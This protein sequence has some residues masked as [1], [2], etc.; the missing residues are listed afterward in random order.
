MTNSNKPTPKDP[1][2]LQD[3][4]GKVE[5]IKDNSEYLRG[6][7][8]KGLQN[9][10][11][12]AMFDDDTMLIKFHGIY[13]QDDRDIRNER[14]DRKL[15]PAYSFMIRL[16]LPGGHLTA[17][18]WIVA[19]DIASDQTIQ[20]I[21]L[22]TR[23]AIQFHGILK[24]DLAPT[25][26]RYH[27]KLL[28]SIAGCGD[29][30]RNVMCSPNPHLSEHH[31]E[32]YD[33]S[34]KISEHLMPTS[35][36]YHEIFVDGKL[37]A[38]GEETVEPLY[39]KH[40]LPRKFKIAIAIPPYNDVDIHAND[41][42]FIAIVE[43]DKLIG[44]NV[45]VGGG[46]GMSHGDDT[47]YPRLASVIGFVKVDDVLDIAY[48]TVQ[49]QRDFGNRIDRKLA[50]FKYTID[51]HSLE[52]FKQELAERSGVNIADEVP[53]I[54]TTNNDRYGWD[55]DHKGRSHLTLFIEGGRVKDTEEYQLKTALRK[56]AE[57]NL[58]DFRLTGNQNIILGNVA[59][60]YKSKI[61]DILNK[62]T[63]LEKT[64]GASGIRKSAIACVA[65][66]TCPLAMAEA[67]RFIPE[68]I[69]RLDVLMEKYGLID[70][71]INIR[72]TGCPN[73]CGRPYLGEIGFVGKALGRYN[74]YL[75]AAH[76]GERLNKLYKENIH[77]SE[78]EGLVQPILEDYSKNAEENESFGDFVI[79]K[80]YIKATVQ[81]LD[82]HS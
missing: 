27:E 73:G 47:T 49:I 54:F 67:E 14:M 34:R 69:T 55:K 52:W 26:Q 75:G 58:C 20:T 35:M 38:G 32:I 57:L 11:T 50:R 13:Q 76:T 39:G 74:M 8:A 64:N 1:Y 23:Q 4:A 68:L 66:N 43:N 36:A 9:P 31:A 22:T 72:V 82:F 53:Y 16:R 41:L 44:Y 28:D 5:H 48:H 60:K 46:M 78:I 81:G 63:V 17:S 62:Y 51:K 70:K 29:V 56:V 45:A 10:L 59:E 2:K 42:S 40:Y 25:I 3:G 65:M 24:R 30:N 79:R 33:M 21:K 6:T 61:E 12:G 80:N 18:Q 15:E 7:I 37:L 19:D 71:A 77:E